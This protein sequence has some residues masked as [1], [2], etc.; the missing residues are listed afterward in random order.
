MVLSDGPVPP[1]RTAYYIEA[2]AR[3]IQYAHDNDILH[4]D[5]KPGNI[6]VDENDRPYLIDL[7]LA[8]SL[9]L[10]DY[11]T[12]TGKALGTAAYMSPE[13][14]RG[15]DKISASADVYGL[16]A[17][18][19]TLLTGRPPFSG[20]S[21]IVILRKVIDEEPV[22]P[23]ERD[24]AVGAELKAICL[25]CL[26]KNPANRFSSADELGVILQKYLDYEPTGVT[27]PK[28]WARL[29]KWVRRQ[30]WRAAA[31]G[32]A[33][34]A[35]VVTALAGALAWTDGRNRATAEALIADIAIVPFSQLP[36]KIERMAD[37]R[38]LINPRL[39]QRLQNS[40][41]DPDLQVRV[42]LALLPCE[43]EHARPLA[44]RILKCG[45][46]EHRVIREA[47]RPHWPAVAPS[48]R[49][50]IANPRADGQE[51]IRAAAALIALDG[52]TTPARPAWSVLQLAPDPGPRVEL[53][54][55]LVR[56]RVNAEVLADR[57]EAEPDVSVR[58][59][60]IQALGA[61]GESPQASTGSAALPARLLAHYRDDPDP[62]V[63]SSLAFTLR[64]WGMNR[65]V[66]MIDLELT[67]KPRGARDWY[68][69]SVGM[70]MAVVTASEQSRPLPPAPGQPPPRFAIA[71]TETPQAVF[72][73]FDPTHAVK[74]KKEYGA[75]PP[76]AVDAPADVISFFEAARFCNWLS[77]RDGLP[78]SEWC[79]Q[80]GQAEGAMELV[81]DYA[82]RLGYR[83]PSVREWVYAARAGTS[84][85]RYFGESDT[86]LND[87][88]WS[89]VNTNY[90]PETVGLLRPND[91][92]LFDV[93][94]NV[95]EWCH[96]PGT[97]HDPNCACHAENGSVCPVLSFKYSLTGS[98]FMERPPSQRLFQKES[99]FNAADPNLFLV[100]SGFRIVR[101]EP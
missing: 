90:H 36:Q 94:G 14:A 39:H 66:K 100:S 26:E 78:P 56:S 33:A 27:L 65:E 15:E 38:T 50:V 31:A 53:L 67:G 88:C 99:Y 86:F 24:K 55:W 69:N 91:F 85:N 84:T 81:P 10:T 2:I 76:R 92:G 17:T 49:A 6:L 59:Q 83:L 89:Y 98:S 34:I 101:L 80:P 48:L 95:M 3:A 64:R 52:P 75:E 8:K 7:G 68:V 87:Y 58:R 77:K 12:L 30:P 71:T 82:G 97:P 72:Q 51:R 20:P 73:E 37:Y 11:T 22:W 43:P 28:P 47:L 60:L 35:I 79:Y 13:Q 54:E 62:G 74:R 25:K 45:I 63:H 32:T 18:L 96:N 46:E 93:I 40:P 21:P 1:R 61:P 4:R 70:T 44:E 41:A 23:R 57:I 9:E 29:A 19:F 42:L 5:V 16:G